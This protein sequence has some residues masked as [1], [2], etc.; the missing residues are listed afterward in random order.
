MLLVSVLVLR[1]TNTDPADPLHPVLHAAH[2]L[3][4]GRP[5]GG[6][7]GVLGAA[8]VLAAVLLPL[9]LRKLPLKLLDP[10]LTFLLGRLSLRLRSAALLRVGVGE[11][12]F[13]FQGCLT[14]PL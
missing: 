10:K 4:Q 2:L 3:L 9:L 13:L 1:N 6:V 8:V 11:D 12:G 5:H 7:V 14:F